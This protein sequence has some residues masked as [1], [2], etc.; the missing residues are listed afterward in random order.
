MHSRQIASQR[1]PF[2]PRPRRSRP[3]AHVPDS[4]RRKWLRRLDFGADCGTRFHQGV[5]SLRPSLGRR[6]ASGDVALGWAQNWAHCSASATAGG[7]CSCLNKTMGLV[8]DIVFERWNTNMCNN[9]ER[10]PAWDRGPRKA[11]FVASVVFTPARGV[12]HP[13]F[14]LRGR[15][16]RSVKSNKQA[17]SPSL[18]HSS[19]LVI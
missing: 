13:S 15:W 9:I 11:R 4:V 7:G 10:A 18:C 12:I 2:F 8:G 5:V 6:R 3:T 19:H 17:P 1:T 14:P 16:E